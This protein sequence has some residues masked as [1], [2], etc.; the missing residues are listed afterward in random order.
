MDVTDIAHFSKGRRMSRTIARAV[1][2]AGNHLLSWT[3]GL[4]AALLLACGVAR[5]EETRVKIGGVDVRLLRDVAYGP[6]KLQRMDIYLPAIAY[7]AAQP[8]PVIL[9]V[10]GGGWAYGD[11]DLGRVVD[12]KVARWVPRGF[13]FVSV[14]YPMV[15]DADPVAQADH[16]AR[17]L[18][19]VQQAAPGW[20]GDPARVILMGHSAGA[21]LVTLLNADEARATRL[22]AKPWLGTVSL[23]SG[24]LD[25]PASMNHKHAKL[26]DTAF[27]ADPALWQAA[28]PQH[29]LKAGA[30]PWLGVC[31]SLRS[32]SC[33]GNA[34]FAAKAKSLGARAEILG[35]KL[36]HSAIN[37]ELGVAGA[38]TD[39]VENFM[40]SLD[41]TV[42]T[43]LGK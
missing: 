4:V 11:K 13:A 31:S 16:I 24:A 6:D 18:A 7:V 37:E 12:N 3:F 1:P 36:R 2:I 39:A 42:K 38:Y 34:A 22:G 8:A 5:A 28:S 23:D 15:P 29:Q 21:H 43:L 20:G 30:R 10:H 26:Y 27:G 35:E 40:A 19:A 33:A 17:A 9:M 32:S 25:V 41:P 14:N